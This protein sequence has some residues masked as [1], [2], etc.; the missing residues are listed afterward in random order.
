MSNVIDNTVYY[1]KEKLFT[2]FCLGFVS[3]SFKKSKQKTLHAFMFN[4]DP[5]SGSVTQS[6][7]SEE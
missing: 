6:N 1:E 3:Y 5:G 7:Y 4:P 2:I